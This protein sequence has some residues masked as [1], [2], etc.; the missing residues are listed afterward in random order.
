MV[1]IV[2]SCNLSTF[3]ERAVL[4]NWNSIRDQSWSIWFCLE[5]PWQERATF[6]SAVMPS[7]KSKKSIWLTVL[8]NVRRVAPRGISSR[9]KNGVRTTCLSRPSWSWDSTEPWDD[10]DM[11]CPCTR[12][13][14][15][16]NRRTGFAVGVMG[17]WPHRELG[18]NPH[19][20]VMTTGSKGSLDREPGL[21]S[22]TTVKN[23]VSKRLEKKPVQKNML[24][25]ATSCHTTVVWN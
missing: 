17:L 1:I 4:N 10:C 6:N 16:G 23:I 14:P 11:V 19:I 3:C 22:L 9:H 7:G 21:A 15:L 20:L 25:S 24:N 18:Y 12:T 13:R 2:R 5:L 8:Q